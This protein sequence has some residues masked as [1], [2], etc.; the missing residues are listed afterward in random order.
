[1]QHTTLFLR[2]TQYISPSR[3]LTRKNQLLDMNHPYRDLVTRC[4]KCDRTA[5]HTLYT[6]Y[7]PD[8]L[9]VCYR[10]AKDRDEAED[11]LQ[12]GFVKIFQKIAR[13]EFQGSFEGWMRRIVV[14]TAIDHI[15]RNKKRQLETDIDEA[16]EVFVA[17]GA[18]GQLELEYLYEIIQE[19]PPGY[20]LVFNLYAIEGYSH[21]EIGEQMG[22]TEST[23]RS[24][25]TRARALLMKRI[26]EDRMESNIYKDAI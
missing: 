8:L 12:E 11:I 23:S 9:A 2:Q 4:Q 1:M 15:R 18:I 13:Y 16:R 26:C 24:Q 5:Q 21:K 25:Y 14:N 7:A 20:R 6:R 3:S 19:L 22:I 17:E 10:Y